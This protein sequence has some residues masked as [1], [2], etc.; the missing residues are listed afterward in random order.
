MAQAYDSNNSITMIVSQCNNVAFGSV[1]IITK[2]VCVC[3]ILRSGVQPCHGFGR[4]GHGHATS[5]C[6]PNNVRHMLLA[7]LSW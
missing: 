2:Q 6:Y 5:I 3:L 7:R 1:S 4:V